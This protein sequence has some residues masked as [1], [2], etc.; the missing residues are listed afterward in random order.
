MN[1]ENLERVKKYIL[2][3]N[4]G[5]NVII[6]NEKMWLVLLSS[7]KSFQLS[8]AEIMYQYRQSTVLTVK[9]S[10][11]LEWFY[12]DNDDYKALG[13]DIVNMFKSQG[14][15]NLIVREVYDSCG[16]ISSCIVDGYVG[17]F[18]TEFDPSDVEFI[19]DIMK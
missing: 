7:G 4:E 13:R 1:R 8:D 15:V 12:S 6:Q 19:D 14:H 5:V 9:A 10:R 16:Y 11:F 3:N 2:D 18:E 17:D